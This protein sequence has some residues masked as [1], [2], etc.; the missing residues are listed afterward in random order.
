M[1]V[2]LPSAQWD[3]TPPSPPR[4][5]VWLAAFVII[6]LTGV[7]STLLT[8]P[9]GEPTNTAWFW[10]RL[11]AFPALAWSFLYGLRLLYHDQETARLRA[12]NDAL[13]E[14]RDKAVEFAQEPLVV[15]DV[16]YLCAMGNNEVAGQIAGGH[17]K[18]GSRDAITGAASIRHT[19][20]SV[21][22]IT[23]MERLGA[24]FIV[25]LRRINTSLLQFPGRAPLEVYLQLPPDAPHD[26]IRD[27]WQHCWNAEK[28]PPVEASFLSSEQGIL[29]LDE[30]L[31]IP[32]GP[33]LEKFA[34]FVA[35]QLHDIPPANSGE[36][37]IALLLG[38]A[39]LTKRKGLTY[40]ALLHRPVEV[41]RSGGAAIQ[42]QLGIPCIEHEPAYH[43]MTAHLFALYALQKIA[44]KAKVTA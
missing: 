29:A 6:M 19:S 44:A 5:I 15:L 25:L 40:Q 10:I 3:T 42:Q 7:I 43:H 17:V 2:E 31:D 4:L 8:W 36:A 39:P 38:W 30:L 28:H 37:A 12:E 20:V 35:V 16:G 22:G 1:P 9:K 18:L 41:D 27:L 26:D 11:L 21:E 34:L 13:T 14:D 32:G 24:C 33:A 23:Q